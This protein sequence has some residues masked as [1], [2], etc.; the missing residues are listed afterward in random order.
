[1]GSWR[2]FLE[3][4]KPPA[5]RTQ[6][7]EKALSDALDDNDRLRKEAARLKKQVR[8]LEAE[9]EASKGRE[10]AERQKAALLRQQAT[11][12]KCRS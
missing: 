1:M 10:E 11:R 8:R 2:D 12:C 4:L 9:Q 7:L 5:V 3:W 6:E